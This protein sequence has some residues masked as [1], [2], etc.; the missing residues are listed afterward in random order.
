MRVLIDEDM[1]RVLFDYHNAIYN[2]D[3]FGARRSLESQDNEVRRYLGTYFPRSFAEQQTLWGR[4]LTSQSLLTNWTKLP[5]LKVLDIGS[6]TGGNVQGILDVVKLSALSH[7]QFDVW[8]TDGNALALEYQKKIVDALTYSRVSWNYLPRVFSTDPLKFRS[9][10]DLLKR[11]IGVD[12][13]DIIVTSKFLS[14]I[15][16][17]AVDEGLSS[18][19]YFENF[20][21][22]AAE[23]LSVNGL[24]IV[25]DV[26][27]KPGQKGNS[28][29]YVPA[30]LRDEQNLAQKKGFQLRCILPRACGY[31]GEQ[32]SNSSR[33][34]FHSYPLTIS[35]SRK[36]E[37]NTK[38]LFRVYA[39]KEF[40][41]QILS[42]WGPAPIVTEM[43]AEYNSYCSQGRVLKSISDAQTIVSTLD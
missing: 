42:D 36:D 14:E 27:I 16:G 12:K 23:N 19:G 32:C 28:P 2:P 22:W 3:P 10:L 38:I 24:L 25:V 8:V 26:P 37:D 18:N 31:Y 4:L 6:G 21:L 17:Y 43:S 33:Y 15:A 35:H 30:M 1:D 39:A 7:V 41:E 29:K 34:C 5:C 9:E 40:A 11:E 20:L 13:F